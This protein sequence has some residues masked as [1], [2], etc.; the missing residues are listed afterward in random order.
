[1]LI[2]VSKFDHC[3][4]DLLYRYRIGALHDRDPG[5][6]VSN[7]RD[8]YQLA[9]RYD[10]PFHHLPVTPETKAAQEARCWS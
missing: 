4:N 2:L 7:H 3:L 10:V 5:A 8:S 1:M 6:I 9:A